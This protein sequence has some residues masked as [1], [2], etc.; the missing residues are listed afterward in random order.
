M[1]RL[2]CGQGRRGQSP[3]GL[4]LGSSILC[5]ESGRPLGCADTPRVHTV[6]P[7]TSGI[8]QTQTETLALNGIFT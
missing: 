2:G 7:E 3:S 4:H 1:A 6:E 5:C 8:F